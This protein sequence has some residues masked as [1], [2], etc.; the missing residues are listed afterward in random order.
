LNDGDPVDR[1]AAN[2]SGNG[3]ACKRR[4]GS[5]VRCRTSHARRFQFRMAEAMLAGVAARLI[6]R[7]QFVN[8][9]ASERGAAARHR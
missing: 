6:S 7:R 3:V 1:F 8:V 4:A 5:P 2:Y 9:A